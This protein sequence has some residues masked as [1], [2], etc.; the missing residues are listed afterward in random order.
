MN[1]ISFINA[2]PTAF[3]ALLGV[4]LGS[5]LTAIT[6][7]IIQRNQNKWMKESQEREWK[8][9]QRHERLDTI[10][11]WQNQWLRSASRT[12]SIEDA[13]LEL[14]EN[15]RHIDKEE[16]EILKIS[17]RKHDELL[18][19]ITPTIRPLINSFGDMELKVCY[20]K[21]VVLISKY[22]SVIGIDDIKT[23]IANN[24][25]I[26]TEVEDVISD[27]QR[28]VDYLLDNPFVITN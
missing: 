19:D 16:L 27:T 21:F 8:R 5:F 12:R 24:K 23:V 13:L 10:L 28:R 6:S 3:I 26:I 22:I 9:Q 18:Q 2:N 20:A 7:Y 17:L 1:I 11:E 14:K 25:Q 15:K 4:V